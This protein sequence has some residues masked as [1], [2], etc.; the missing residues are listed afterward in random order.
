MVGNVRGGMQPSICDDLISYLA[1]ASPGDPD[2]RRLFQKKTSMHCEAGNCALCRSL[3]AIPPTHTNGAEPP[4]QPREHVERTTSS[5]S[6]D[7]ADHN[8][9]ASSATHEHTTSKLD[10]LRRWAFKATSSAVEVKESDPDG[11]K[12]LDLLG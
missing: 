8:D 10:K 5:T 2:I 1:A 11:R 7:D 6:T 9:R 3:N 12:S 4:H